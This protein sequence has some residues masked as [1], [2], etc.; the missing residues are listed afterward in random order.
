MINWVLVVI[1]FLAKELCLAGLLEGEYEEGKVYRHRLKN[2]LTILTMERHNVPFIFHQLTYKVGSVNE[3]AGLTGI[4]HVVEHM[5]F[6]GTKKYAKGQVSKIISQNSGIFNAFTSWDM[7]SYYMYLPKNK[8]EL[9]FDIES[10]R[11]QNSIFDT[12]EFKS[13]IRVV[14]QERRMRSESN[15]GGIFLENLYST[16]FAVS[17]YRN[18][19]IGWEED[20]KRITRD[21]AY[22][23]YKQYYT[24]NNAI[25]VLVGDF[26]TK[27]ILRLAEKYYGTIPPGPEIH[28]PNVYEPAQ[29]AKKMFSIV[30]GDVMYP[31]VLMAFKTPSYN[32][33][34]APAL[35]LAGKILCE[36][37]R[38]SRL[39]KRLVEN[40]KLA[41]SVSGGF[42]ISK[43]PRLFT[44]SI[45]VNPDSN[46][47]RIEKIVWE[48][49]EKM[50]RELV[51]DYEL[52]KAK[53]RYKF[54]EAS[55]YIKNSDIGMRLSTWECYYGWDYY[56][57]FYN[58]VLNVAREDIQRVMNEYFK[59]SA[60]TVGYLLPKEKKSIKFEDEET[61]DF[62]PNAG[63]LLEL[64]IIEDEDK[65]FYQGD[66]GIFLLEGLSP[67]GSLGPLRGSEF[68]VD[69]FDIVKPKPIS[70][71]VK[72]AKLKNGITV[73]TIE[74]K[75]APTLVVTG[76]I[77][78]GIIPDE[79]E[80]KAGIASILADVMNRGPASMS[81]DEYVEKL[82]FYPISIS[83]RGNYRG[84]SFEGYS[85]T[86][87]SDQMLKMLVEVLTNPRMDTAE[88]NLIKNKHRT[89][90]KNRFTGT[91]VKAFYYMF[92]KIFR[93]HEYSKNKITPET[94]EKISTEDIFKLYESYIRPDRTTL[95]VVGNMK[96]KDM[97]S[98]VKRYFEKWQ[99]KGKPLPLRL[100]SNVKELNY[101]EMKVF[102][103]SEYT[104]CTINLGFAPYNNI[105]K[106]EE[107]AVEILNYIL[108]QSALTSRIGV[109]LRDKQGLIYMIRSQL[110]QTRDGIGYWK[111][112]TK[113]AP[114]NVD[115]VIKGIFAEIKKLL[116]EG[117]TDE[118][119]FNAKRRMLGLLPLYAETPLDVASVV[120]RSLI[121]KV[122]LE[123]FDKK[124]EK[125]L[126]VS[127]E[128][129]MKV[130]RK[131][132]TLDK[133]IVVVDGPI[134]QEKLQELIKID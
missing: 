29:K 118:E 71:K 15:S 61:E 125:I 49:I 9:A 112:N 55:E 12:A 41:L 74:N 84:F 51:S 92:D 2:G 46:V 67:T 60:V 65:F 124:Y 25:L 37:S 80:G 11:M 79:I 98:L 19:I 5:M 108:A 75:L 116:E 48:E 68:I 121:E 59:E 57:N 94:I 27:E 20:L 106:D 128:D 131:Y 91:K 13:E 69:T 43:Y 3:P 101:R 38:G 87:N 104:E 119:L 115:K 85:L 36:R 7:T 126:K 113:T 122:P 86:E 22:T 26:D 90:A 31:T 134:T 95:I 23:Y 66:F 77:E 70:P 81:Y 56:N 82:S 45:Q 117:I 83:V 50:K 16:A 103:D 58:M 114:E 17:P 34:D 6:K 89:V 35:Y 107:E 30:H 130:A 110:W 1:L 96:H 62:E 127:K 73:Y 120:A 123:E 64:S 105:G 33:P 133:F 14:L 72:K 24:P 21:D 78:A 129:V 102:P 109:E 76:I 52:Q 111:L 8:I 100:V 53:N 28:E 39:Y 132:L 32:H 4:S 97:L 63:R 18:P 88:I 99:A 47:D 10:D 44:I 40:E 54:T 93:D 42:P